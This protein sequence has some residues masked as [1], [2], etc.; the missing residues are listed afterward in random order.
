MT[1]VSVL[2][3]IYN[4]NPTHL[5]QMIESILNQTFQ[6]FEFLILNDSPQ[7]KEP[8]KIVKEYNDKRIKYFKN[9]TNLGISDS[10]NK[11]LELA[12]GEY[13]AIFDHDDISLP[14]RLEKEVEILDKNPDIGVVSSNIKVIE[15]NKPSRFPQN[16]IDIKINLVTRGC[17]LA[18]S[19]SMIRKKVLIE[20]QINWEK[21]FSPCEDYMLFG[22]LI[23]KTMFYCIKEVL[24]LYRAHNNNTSHTKSE[25]MKDKE[26]LIK[27]FLAKEYPIF[28]RSYRKYLLFGHIPL[29][30]KT[31]KHKYYLF[32]FIPLLKIKNF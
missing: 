22:R 7:N 15:T 6:D 25:L 2:T 21:D 16:N 27:N 19:A 31:A 11:L 8:E 24:L 14:T 32:G 3:P 4:T 29:L 18:H 28:N 26:L 5:R 13:L 17:V 23:G 10:R 30:K 12:Q 20:N 1:K 9:E